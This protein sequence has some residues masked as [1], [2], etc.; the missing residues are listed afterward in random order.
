MHLQQLPSMSVSESSP[1]VDVEQSQLPWYREAFYFMFYNHGE[2]LRTVQTFVWCL[3][4]GALGGLVSTAYLEVLHYGLAVVWVDLPKLLM[5]DSNFFGPGHCPPWLLILLTSSFFGL[6]TGLCKWLLPDAGTVGSMIARMHHKG[7]VSWQKLLPIICIT[8]TSIFAGSSV[9]PEAAVVLIMGYIAG[10]IAPKLTRATSSRRILSIAAMGAGLS[11]F[12]DLPLG[13]ALFVLELLHPDSL[14]YFEAIAPTVAASLISTAVASAIQQKTIGGIYTFMKVPQISATQLIYSVCYGAIGA[15]LASLFAYCTR[16]LQKLASLS[17]VH[18]TSNPVPNAILGAVAFGF[19][20][21]LLPPTLF[22]S[23]HELQTIVDGGMTALPHVV[24]PGIL[25]LSPD[26]DSPYYWYSFLAI[27]LA[28][29]F[30]IAMS[31]AAGYNGGIIFPLFFV[32]ASIAQVIVHFFDFVSPTLVI[33][34]LSG[35]VEAAIT[36]TPI[37][38]A[39]C[40]TILHRTK[41]SNSGSCLPIVV[42]SCYTSVILTKKLRF[43]GT[44]RHRLAW[45]LLEKIEERRAQE[46]LI[47]KKRTLSVVDSESVDKLINPALYVVS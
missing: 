25:H 1:L 39:I 27:G 30:T 18:V 26:S 38:T 22:W 16:W 40:L 2:G 35:A 5:K 42:L 24:V 33:L 29:I 31:L 17:R 45:N 8:L 4:F 6:L 12:F 7:Y 19:I 20:G 21:A 28:K 14:E 3:I 23:E 32:G 47:E 43:F 11:A 13:G 46:E 36:R 15:I 9:G 10:F 44:Q 34:A 41:E 37:S